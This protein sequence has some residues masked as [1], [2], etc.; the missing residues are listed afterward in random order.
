MK[1]AMVASEAAPLIKTGGLGDVMQ[2][3]PAELSRMKGNE[4]ALILPY[5]GVMKRNP[6][7]K[8]EFIT[9]FAVSMAWRNCHVGVFRV[10]SRKKL[11]IYLVDN[12]QYFNRSRVYGEGD[13]GERFAYFAKA[14]L[15]T[16]AAVGFI[17]DVIQ[18]NDWQTALVPMLLKSEFSS[19]FPNTKTLFTIHNV[20]YQGWGNN[21]FNMDVLGLPAEYTDI[22]DMGG[23]SNFMKSAVVM[24]DAVSTVSESYAGELMHPYFAHGMD[25]MLR[26]N[27]HKM[28]GITNGIDPDAFN[29]QTDKRLT[30]C[31]DATTVGEGKKAN[32]LALQKDLG[33]PQDEDCA[34]LAMVSRLV[35]HKGIDLLTNI[36]DRLL[37]RRV[38][39][40]ILGTGDAQYEEFF[41]ALQ[42]K[43]PQQVAA[44]L[45]FD[46]GL[47]NRIYAAADLYLMPSKSEPCGLSQ[48]IAMR[49]GTVPIVHAVG[50]LKDTVWPFDPQSG[51]GRG[52]TFQSYNAE[53]FLYAIDRALDV[54]YNQKEAFL[55]LREQ[56]M[57]ED[58]SWRKPAKEY[59]ALF[60]AL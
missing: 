4:V 17:P 42:E 58:F 46:G 3:L 20:E 40:V 45:Q 13:D 5:Y 37:D 6:A 53:D 56:D 26:Q 35:S 57:K 29:P 19:T 16:L 32:K 43:Y 23:A 31:Y 55:R 49:Y 24:A 1:I 11:Q 41:R 54:F 9:S 44:V 10:K 8:T 7:I 51:K 12:E 21:C 38:Q 60:G 28:R 48:I 30:L 14:A 25:G 39:L 36:A 33:L 27:A 47:A 22:M 18:C 52:F 34:M 50:G 2:G 15:S 59:M